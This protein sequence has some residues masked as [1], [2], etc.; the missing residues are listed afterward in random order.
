[1]THL[2]C[3]DDHNYLHKRYRVQLSFALIAYSSTSARAGAIYAVETK[4]GTVLGTAQNTKRAVKVKTLSF[5]TLYYN[6]R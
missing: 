2:W 5:T 1:M 4:S 3:S 6:S